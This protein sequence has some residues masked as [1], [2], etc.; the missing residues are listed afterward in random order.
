MESLDTWGA[1]C[2]ALGG[3]EGTEEEA[4]VG[5]SLCQ[6]GDREGRLD[7]KLSGR[8]TARQ[9]DGLEC[10]R[11]RRQALGSGLADRAAPADPGAGTGSGELPLG[12][13]GLPLGGEGLMTLGIH[14]GR[15]LSVSGWPEPGRRK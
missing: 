8:E 4:W 15:G 14:G 5:A 3:R 13:E 10:G 1:P 2:A 12:E 6:E 11:R 9:W 7:K